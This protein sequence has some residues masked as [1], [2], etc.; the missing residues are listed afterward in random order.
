VVRTALLIATGTALAFT[1]GARAEPTRLPL[2]FHV[3]QPAEDAGAVV[4]GD[5]FLERQLERANAIFAPYAIAFAAKQVRASTARAH[6][7][8]RADRDA[9]GRLVEPGV[10][11]C[12][13]VASLRDV[14]EPA[15][16]RSGVH[17]R[18]RS[19]PGA[20]YVIL[21]ATAHSDVLAHE[22][23]HFM[24]NPRHSATP[25]NLMSYQRT[26][27]LPF[28]DD[29]QQR[30]MRRRLE[31]YLRS[32]ELRVERVQRSSG[33]SPSPISMSSGGSEIRGDSS[34]RNDSASIDSASPRASSSSP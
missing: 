24:G 8:T 3:T 2:V 12:F 28:L 11:N 26:E 18:S 20:H 22:L 19:V 21:S 33:S 5:A 14:D 13:V 1:T 34:G 23:G 15:R 31:H 32:G 7:Q 30:R 29:A 17:W 4:A 9:L 10:I 27:A 16:M 25:G 6:M